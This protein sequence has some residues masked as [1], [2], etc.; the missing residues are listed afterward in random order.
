M[1]LTVEFS[2][3]WKHLRKKGKGEK[4]KALPLMSL[5]TNLSIGENYQA[6]FLDTLFI[7]LYRSM[8]EFLFNVSNDSFNYLS[9]KNPVPG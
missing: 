2:L 3:N 5:D 7:A 6:F 8:Y 1:T 4:I 9:D